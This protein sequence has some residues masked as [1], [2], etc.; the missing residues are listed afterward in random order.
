MD[1]SMAEKKKKSRGSQKEQATPKKL[2]FQESEKESISSTF[3]A[4]IFCQNVT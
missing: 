3:Y 2:F 4:R 1:Q